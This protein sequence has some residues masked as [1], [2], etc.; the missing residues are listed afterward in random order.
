MWKRLVLMTPAAWL[1]CL[2]CGR[3]HPLASDR[4]RSPDTNLQTFQVRG[5]VIS[6]NPAGKEVQ[7]KHE[8]IPGYMP[9]MTMPFD[10]KDTNDLA[11][12]KPGDPVSFRLTVARTDAWIDQIVKASAA[13][14]TNGPPTSG[15]FRQ[16]RDV[17]PLSVGEVLPAC[18]LTNQFGQAF[19]TAD[20]RGQA[21]AITFLFTRCPFPTFCPRMAVSFAE[22]QGKMLA[23]AGGATNWHLL[24]ISFDP[25]FDTPAVLKAYGERFKYDPQHWTLATGS[26]VE[27]TAIADR[28]GLVFWH[29]ENGSISHNLRTAVIDARGRI[30]KLFEGNSWTSDELAAA[31]QSATSDAR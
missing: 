23:R 17:E 26:L 14:Q 3:E 5:L 4:G 11:Q 12:L 29:D 15:M 1:L 25:Q 2:G 10:V 22:T 9:A 8:A 13:A 6:L 20:F 31:L 27:V 18:Q 21:M 7:I 16:V 19:S 28:F 24:T 30:Q